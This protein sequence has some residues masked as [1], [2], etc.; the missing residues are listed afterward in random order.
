MFYICSVRLNT[1]SFVFCVS[2]AI[3]ERIFESTLA[4]SK[5]EIANSF[6]YG[7]LYFAHPKI[8]A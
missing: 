4:S 3:K 7:S 8:I 2:V 6:L 1:S 5:P